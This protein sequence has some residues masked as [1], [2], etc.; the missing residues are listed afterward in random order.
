ML[1]CF[2]L[3]D[4]GLVK[5]IKPKRHLTFNRYNLFTGFSANGKDVTVNFTQQPHW[6]GLVSEMELVPTSHP[7][8]M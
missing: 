8:V 7:G 4:F 6:T 3:Q 5:L 1:F 2:R